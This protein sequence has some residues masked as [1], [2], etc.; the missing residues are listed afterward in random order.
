M[1]LCKMFWNNKF[2]FL[3]FLYF[4]KILSTVFYMNCLSERVFTVWHIEISYITPPFHFFYLKIVILILKDGRIK[5]YEII[6]IC[7]LNPSTFMSFL[8][9]LYPIF[10]Y[11]KHLEQNKKIILKIKTILIILKYHYYFY[12][13]VKSIK[14][15]W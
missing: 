2:K 10:S 12:Y 3:Y 8:Y 9:S 5:R 7:Y 11:F 4:D 15:L 1:F 14:S 13:F 6:F